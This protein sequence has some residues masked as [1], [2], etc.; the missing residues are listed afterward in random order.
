MG[1]SYEV[2][3]E[4]PTT[5]GK[6]IFAAASQMRDGS[7]PHGEA[8]ADREFAVRVVRE[9]RAAGH[10][11]YWAGGCVRDQ[12]LGLVPKDYDVA[13]DAIPE[14]VRE[15]FGHRRTLAI[16]ASFGVISV[17]GPKHVNAIEVATFRRD[18]AYSDG[19]HPDSVAFS[20]AREDAQRRDFTIN[21]LFFDPL[22]DEVIDYVGGQDDLRRGIVRAIGNPAERITEDKL[23]MLRGIRFAATFAFALD[24]ATLAAIERQAHELVI[25][26][27]ERIAAEMRR[28]LVHGHRERAL[29]LLDAAGLLEIV[30][31][32]AASL[33]PLTADGPWPRTLRVLQALNA[34]GRPTFAVAL[35][36]L[37]REVRPADDAPHPLAT[38][39]AGRWRLANDE[40]DGVTKLLREEPLV[41][42]ASQ[43][44]WPQLQRILVAPRIAEL[45]HLA[46]AVAQQTDGHTAEIDYCRAKLALPAAEL[47]PPPLVTGN[48]LIAAGLSAGPRFREVLEAIRDA[49]LERRIATAD[50]AL[51]LA[52]ELAAR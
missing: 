21:G 2:S 9:L 22:R 31:P 46:A 17:L 7:V 18:A 5:I 34:F 41:R 29:Q 6:G 37:L 52:R 51:A 13:T 12:L 33:E 23:R 39:V 20:D 1:K 25:V 43:L 44:P 49:Q 48:D 50:E 19:R 30:L 24:G 8:N 36:A 15:L 10:V 38:T 47:N 27:A 14:R 28:M 11:A 35:A 40:R 26:S 3:N 16:G 42:R 32:E 4:R 45:L